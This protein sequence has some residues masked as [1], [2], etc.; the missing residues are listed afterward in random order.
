M[1][2]RA[3]YCNDVYIGTNQIKGYWYWTWLFLY[4]VLSLVRGV[5]KRIHSSAVITRSRLL[6]WLRWQWQSVSQTLDS[7]KTFHASPTRAS[8]GLIFV[9]YCEENW[10]RYKGTALYIEYINVF[11]QQI[12]PCS[13]SINTSSL[14][15]PVDGVACFISLSAVVL[16]TTHHPTLSSFQC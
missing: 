4:N 7:Q 16:I 2:S 3:C 13:P 14:Y 1:I 10:P 8:Y 5:L 11:H 6:R 9:R 15:Y 12:L